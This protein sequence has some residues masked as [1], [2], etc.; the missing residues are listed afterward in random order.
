MAAGGRRGLRR[1]GSV[2]YKRMRPAA[3]MAPCLQHSVPALAGWRGK[4]SVPLLDDLLDD[5]EAGQCD[6]ADGTEHTGEG[7]EPAGGGVDGDD[8]QAGGHGR[9]VGGAVSGAACARSGRRP[10]KEG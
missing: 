8:L 9:G 2:S 4:G 7:H 10:P 5:E 3:R 6:G 1:A